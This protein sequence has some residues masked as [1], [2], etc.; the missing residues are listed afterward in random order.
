VLFTIGAPLLRPS[1]VS[2]FLLIYVFTIR[3]VN[4]AIMLYSPTSQVLSVLAW[5]YLSDG[6]LAQAAVVGLIQTL[7][8]VIGLFIARFALG[9]STSRSALS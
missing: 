4:T 2:A 8:M 5:N 6:S 3:E 7:L 1:L 9:V